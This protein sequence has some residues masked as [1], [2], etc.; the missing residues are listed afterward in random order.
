M[1]LLV[2]GYTVHSKP[3]VAVIEPVALPPSA[4]IIPTPLTVNSEA[5]CLIVTSFDIFPAF[6]VTVTLRSVPL[7]FT[8]AVW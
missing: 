7:G 6:I 5:V 3:S 1:L 4:G 2:S 8:E